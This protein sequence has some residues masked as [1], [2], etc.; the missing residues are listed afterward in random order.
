[1]AVKRLYRDPH[2]CEEGVAEGRRGGRS[3]LT[4]RTDA[5]SSTGAVKSVRA[6][7]WCRAVSSS[8]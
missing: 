1:M 4:V 8:T 5:S 7:A 2:F 6:A 3:C